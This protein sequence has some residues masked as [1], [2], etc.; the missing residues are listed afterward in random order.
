MRYAITHALKLHCDIY[1]HYDHQPHNAWLIVYTSTTSHTIQF[2]DLTIHACFSL[3]F[4]NCYPVQDTRYMHLEMPKTMH[5]NRQYNS[6]AQPQLTIWQTLWVCLTSSLKQMLNL[7]AGV[8]EYHGCIAP[9]LWPS[10]ALNCCPPLKARQ[11]RHVCYTL[12]IIITHKFSANGYLQRGGLCSPLPSPY[13]CKNEP[14]AITKL[15]LFSTFIQH[16]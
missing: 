1:Q 6:F 5:P 13:I 8:P 10:S 14:S 16:W 3:T 15:L 12:V 4:T 2:K 11:N 7:F 9:V